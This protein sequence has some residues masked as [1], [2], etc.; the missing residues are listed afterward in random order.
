MEAFST[1]AAVQTPEAWQD[2]MRSALIGKGFFQ[3]VG[4]LHTAMHLR[5]GRTL[6]VAFDW[7]EAALARAPSRLPLGLPAALER[8][9]SYLGLVSD[10]HDWFR[11]GALHAFFDHMTDDDFFD[12]FDSVLFL[13]IG[14]CGYA[15]C[16]YSVVAPGARVLAVGPQ[17][18]LAR[19]TT[20][21]DNRFPEA[22]RMNF[23][24]RYGYAPEMIE[25]A[26]AMLLLYDPTV[27]EDAMHAA[28]FTG[29]HVTKLRCRHMAGTL[30]GMFAGTDLL[31]RMLDALRGG[32]TSRAGFAALMRTRHDHRP[33]LR[34]FTRRVGRNERPDLLARCTAAILARHDDR[35]IRKFHDAALRK[36]HS[37][38]TD[39]RPWQAAAL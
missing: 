35:F 4:D 11:D 34:Q 15:A 33:Y 21:W 39:A 16:A 32:R 30:P 27:A 20:E 3:P 8:G 23:T 2:A 13:G 22:R 9:W 10:R 19:N 18:T 36:L 31:G 17:A 6:L 37:E 29:E 5:Q 7:R 28:Q 12:E 25:A 24:D 14:S 1:L 26:D 38:E